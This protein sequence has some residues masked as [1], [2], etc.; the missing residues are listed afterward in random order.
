MCEMPFYSSF[1]NN[2]HITFI[3]QKDKELSAGH[4]KRVRKDNFLTSCIQ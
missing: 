3:I 1:S 2:E 4:I